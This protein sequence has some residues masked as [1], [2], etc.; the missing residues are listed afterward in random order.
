MVCTVLKQLMSG[1]GRNHAQHLHTT[2]TCKATMKQKT[3]FHPQIDSMSD[4]WHCEPTL[5]WQHTGNMGSSGDSGGGWMV[6]A[7]AVVVVLPPGVPIVWHHVHMLVW[8]PMWNRFQYVL[9]FNRTLLNFCL[10]AC[11][12]CRVVIVVCSLW[13]HPS[14]VV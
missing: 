7:A 1:W 3:K 14:G 2:E 11:L 12:I 9:V 5:S 4:Q 13:S 6:A 10:F 8:H